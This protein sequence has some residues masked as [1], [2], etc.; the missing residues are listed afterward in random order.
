MGSFARRSRRRPWFRVVDPGDL[1]LVMPDDYRLAVLRLPSFG[2]L[3]VSWWVA[4]KPG[5]G[6]KLAPK[7]RPRE[8]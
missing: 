3:A 6:W 4:P 2:K 8:S 7:A 1:K 5:G